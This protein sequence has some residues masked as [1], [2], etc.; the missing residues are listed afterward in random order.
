MTLPKLLGFLKVRSTKDGS[1]DSKPII[2]NVST[3]KSEEHS[4]D[5]A[6]IQEGGYLMPAAV[7]GL[8]EDTDI[9]MPA[10]KHLDEF[11]AKNVRTVSSASTARSGGFTARSFNS[12]SS[13]RPL[14]KVLRE[15]EAIPYDMG[16]SSHASVHAS[17]FEGTENR[18]PQMLKT[19]LSDVEKFIDANART[20][21][22]TL[23]HRSGNLTARSLQS[24]CSSRPVTK[25][26]RDINAF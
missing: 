24:G 6:D 10:L 12:A 17:V 15:I 1:V 8:R 18:Q 14:S 11:I 5:Q 21:S 3:P 16:D 19:A 4:D 2:T 23:T 13:S 25:I 20:I 7:I 22:D 9:D 26:L